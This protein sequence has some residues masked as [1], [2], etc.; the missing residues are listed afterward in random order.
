MSGSFSYTRS[1]ANAVSDCHSVSVCVWV[2]VCAFCFW[3]WRCYTIT[4]TS[5]GLDTLGPS[6]MK[7]NIT[8]N[9]YLQ[10]MSSALFYFFYCSWSDRHKIHS[11]YMDLGKTAGWTLNMTYSHP[12]DKNFCAHMYIQI[13]C[14]TQKLPVKSNNFFVEHGPDLLLLQYFSTA[15]S[16]TV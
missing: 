13:Q 15:R 11:W 12:T 9:T 10:Y 14:S 3:F 7:E 4:S 6:L 8:N 1:Q 2:S 16:E 5:R